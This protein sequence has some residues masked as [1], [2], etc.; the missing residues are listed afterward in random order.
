MGSTVLTS[1]RGVG[2]EVTDEQYE[3]HM[4]KLKIFRSWFDTNIMSLNPESLSDTIMIMPYGSANPKYR[5]SP[6]E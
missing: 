3:K 1:H 5:D 2:K 4:E 6:N